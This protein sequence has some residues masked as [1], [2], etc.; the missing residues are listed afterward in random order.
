MQEWVGKISVQSPG[1]PVGMF[2]NPKIQIWVNFRGCSKL[3]M[4]VYYMD[5][6]S[7]FYCLLVYF[8]VIFVVYFLPFWYFVPRTIW[9]PCCK[10]F[11][12]HFFYFGIFYTHLGII[13]GTLVYFLPFWYFVPRTIWQPRFKRFDQHFLLLESR[14][15]GVDDDSLKQWAFKGGGNRSPTSGLTFW[16]Q[17]CQM[18]CFQ[19]KSPNLGNFGRPCNEKS[20]YI[21][22]PF[23]I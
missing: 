17:G 18:V 12:R 6:W 8:I 11:D 14:I 1:M 23:G 13:C 7:I 3:K 22:W 20:W 2:S 19:T 21:L 16:C 5:I 15:V 9:Q 10:R 4:L